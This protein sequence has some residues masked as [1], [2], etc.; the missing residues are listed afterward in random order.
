MQWQGAM[1]NIEGWAFPD[2]ERKREIWLNCMISWGVSRAWFPLLLF[3]K[4]P[5]LVCFVLKPFLLYEIFPVLFLSCCL[6]IIVEL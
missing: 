2:N 4:F 1:R 6:L 3:K 5:F